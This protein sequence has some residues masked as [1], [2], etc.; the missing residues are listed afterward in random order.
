M[1]LLDFFRTEKRNNNFLN[2]N[3]SF[4]FGGAANR[5]SV[6]TDSS[7]TFSAVFA[8]VRIISESI[9]SLPVRVY[10]VETDGDKIEE[11]SHP[12]NRLL[13]RKPNDFMTTYTFLD[14]LMNNLLLEGN[15]YFYIERDSS[16]RPVGLIPIKTQHVKVI[17]H[18]GQIY[19]DVK[20]YDLAIR[21]EDMLHFFNLS[22]NGYEGTSVIGSQRTTIGTS[23]ASNDTANSYL[24]NSSQIGGIIKHPGKLS[25]EAVARLKTSWNQSTTGSFVAGKTAILEEGM[26]FEQ[27]KINANDYQLLETRRFQIEEIA[28]I[29]KVPLSLIGHLEKAANYSSIEALSIDFVRF[30]LQPYLVLIEQEL[31]RKLFRENELDNY[32]VRLDSKGLLRGDSAARATYYRE[33]SAIGVLSINEIRRMEDLNRIGDEGDTHYYPLNFA[34]IGQTEE[35]E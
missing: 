30:T 5:T 11:V 4:S 13:T 20:D 22:F 27:S 25:K 17:N 35:N 16:A 23:I 10:R 15:S 12:V 33:M 9:A 2:A 1:G 29:F 34:P 32:F 6:T 3:S 8:C 21:K 28:R 26:T 18:D 24:G 19:Y 31:N 7:M 14:V